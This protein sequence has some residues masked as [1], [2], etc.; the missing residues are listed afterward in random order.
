MRIEA[1]DRDSLADQEATI[2]RRKLSGAPLGGSNERDTV[3]LAAL[4][5]DGQPVIPAGAHIRL[6]APAT[7]GGIRFLRRGYSFTDGIDSQTG[8]LDG[9]LFF[10]CFQRDPRTGFVPVQTRLA[11][12]DALNEYV[13]HVGS[14]LFAIPPG[15]SPGGYIGETLFG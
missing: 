14:G 1:W 7:T 15:T 9:G 6:A 8:Q 13:Q 10:V 4:A 5:A 11:A 2:G 3:N 12:S